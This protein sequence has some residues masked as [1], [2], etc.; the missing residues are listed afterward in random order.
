MKAHEVE[1]TNKAGEKMIVS[2]DYFESNKD[3]LTKVATSEKM[4]TAT[5]KNKSK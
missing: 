1:V 4:K 2:T 3:Q 5:L